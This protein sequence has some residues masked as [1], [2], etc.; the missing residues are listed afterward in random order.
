M[1]DYEIFCMKPSETIK[2][3]CTR[4]TNNT[5]CLLKVGKSYSNAE[6]VRQ[7]F[8]ILPK[9]YNLLA[10]SNKLAKDINLVLLDELLGDLMPNKEEMASGTKEESSKAK[11]TDKRERLE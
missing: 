3:M 2:D 10:T 9:E 11:A 7:I 1:H 6:L 8:R 4:F 5:N